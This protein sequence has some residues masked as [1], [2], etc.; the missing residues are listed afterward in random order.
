MKKKVILF[1]FLFIVCFPVYASE[2]KTS[3]SGNTNVDAK[4][5]FELVLKISGTDIWGLTASL[6]YDT[7]KLKLVSYDGM[8]GFDATVK[9][10][11]VLDG[12]GNK[13]GD[14][15]KL[16]FK[17]IDGFM[18]GESTTIT[19]SNVKGATNTEKFTGLGCDKKITVNIPKSSNSNLYDLKIGGKTIDGFSKDKKSYNLGTVDNDKINISGL[20][21]DSR[22][23]ISGTGDHKLSYGENKFD[24]VVKAEEGSTSTYTIIVNR[25]DTRSSNNYLS[26]LKISNGDIKFNKNTLIYNVVVDN[27]VDSITIDA[28]S[29]DGKAT[30]NGLGKKKLNVYANSFEIVVIAENESKRVYKIN[31][32]RKDENGN[33]GE[34]SDNNDLSKLEII[35]Y[36]IEFKNDILDYNLVVEYD[37]DKLEIDAIADDKDA[38]VDIKNVDKLVIGNNL[39]IVSV[40]AVNGD[41]KEYKINVLKKDNTPVVLLSELKDTIMNSNANVITVEVNDENTILN[42]DIIK[43]LKNKDILL[44]INKYVDDKIKYSWNIDGKNIDKEFEFDTKVEMTSKNKDKIENLTNYVDAI[45]LDYS[46]SG[47]LPKNTE[48]SLYVLDKYNEGD[49]LNLYYYDSEKNEL[50]LE[51]SNLKVVDGYIKYEIEHCSDYILTKANINKED[52]SIDFKN[53][54]IIIESILMVVMFSILFVVLRKKKNENIVK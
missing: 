7:S 13:S 39:I 5:E 41:K 21:E 47:M 6:N 23:T 46:Y 15:L 52:K 20:V 3:L 50:I 38:I 54:L 27:K 53:V 29:E 4:G 22:A 17:A 42:K 30:V 11:I 12:D 35:G 2:L 9:S 14:V 16:K 28:K 10:N 1:I 8:N 44:K 32:S 36:D 26:I 43:E 37:V 40:T 45:Y 48:F 34:L 24:V 31:V 51:K 33:V 18:P 49:I 25:R 19:I